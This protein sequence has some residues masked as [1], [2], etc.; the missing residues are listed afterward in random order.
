MQKNWTDHQ[1]YCLSR[2]GITL[3]QSRKALLPDDQSIADSL[4][5]EGARQGFDTETTFFGKKEFASLSDLQKIALDCQDCA[6]AQSRNKVVWGQGSDSA[7]LMIVADFPSDADNLSGYAIS[8]SAG[9]L[10]KKMLQAIDREISDVFVTCMVKCYTSIP[11]AEQIETACKACG[12]YL[13]AQIAA[14]KP[15]IIFALGEYGFHYLGGKN[16]I[17]GQRHSEVCK[18]YPEILLMPGFHPQHLLNNPKDKRGAWED[19]KKIKAL[20]DGSR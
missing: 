19:L 16:F 20:L 1:Q 14:I 6:L 4:S 7:E 12:Y 15:E 8:S 5:E 10:L 17:P 2:M 9:D 13:D 11:Q 3:W 18:Q